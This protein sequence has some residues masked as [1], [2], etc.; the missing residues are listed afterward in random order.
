[1]IA[2]I[3]DG[4]LRFL[5]KFDNYED[6]LQNSERIISQFNS[7]PRNSRYGEYIYCSG[8]NFY[9][10]KSFNRNEVGFGLYKNLDDATFARNLLKDN[11]WDLS[12][13]K[14]LA[15]VCFSSIHNQYV[16]FDVVDEK[17]IVADK[18]D[19]QSEALGNAQK[20]IE[21]YRK[22]K[23]G[24]GEKHVVFN[25]RLFAVQRWMSGKINYFGSFKELE[26][27]VAVRNLLV[28]VDWDLSSIYENRIYE[29]N[30]YFYKF[31]IFEG[32]VK[33]I[34][35][36]RNNEDAQSNENNLSNLTY[37]DIYDPENQY[38]KVNRHISKRGGK[39]WIKKNIDGQPR[40]FG[41]F[42]T[43]SDAIDARDK[44][45]EMGWN[46]DFDEQSIYSAD[47]DS[48]DSFEEVISKLS[49]WQRIIYDT[50]VRLDKTYFS[51]EELADHSFLK[52]YKSANYIQKVSKHLQE[53][54]DLGLVTQLEE[55]IFKKEF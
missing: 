11:N 16:V 52:R 26:D 7:N 54:V 39:F 35:K 20:S 28:D 36:F 49:M 31:H 40:I 37:E 34:G 4:K 8:D 14:E 23:Y 38:S 25:G 3:A 50:I 44:Y 5:E 17:V 22:S 47:P 30:D 33:I 48:D 13:V 43:R 2:S 29:I 1:M 27:A 51:F 45:E 21:E 12:K 15:P 9:I 24:T 10:R 19:S 41:P 55:N 46:I 42:D 32:T 6:A 53:L 18:F